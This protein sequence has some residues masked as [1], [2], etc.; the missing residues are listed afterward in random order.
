MLGRCFLF[1][2]MVDCRMMFL[3]FFFMF[4]GAFC[5]FFEGDA[6]SACLPEHVKPV[7]LHSGPFV[8]KAAPVVIEMEAGEEA[9]QRC[10]A[11]YNR[12]AFFLQ[13]LQ[14]ILNERENRQK[15]EDLMPARKGKAFLTCDTRIDRAVDRMSIAFLSVLTVMLFVAPA[16][17]PFWDVANSLCF[18]AVFC[19]GT[20]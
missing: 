14:G 7:P 19:W 20:A 3:Y 10:Q 5:S 8:D 13:K 11:C 2:D 4:S 1:L 17:L 16:P 15:Q 6:G 9:H 18:L 12:D